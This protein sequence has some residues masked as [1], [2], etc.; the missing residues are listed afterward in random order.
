MSAIKLI[1]YINLTLNEKQANAN[2]LK[3]SER[4]LHIYNTRFGALSVQFALKLVSDNN[5]KGQHIIHYKMSRVEPFKVGAVT[6]QKH[7]TVDT[8]P[9][10][11]YH[12]KIFKL[13]GFWRPESPTYLNRLHI[14]LTHTGFGVG[15]ML[16]LIVTFAYLN[17]LGEKV[18]KFLIFS[19]TL[20]TTVK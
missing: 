14:F 8:R 20:L 9:I 6:E 15:F 3:I 16:T 17:S 13:Y 7:F 10:F 11:D 4:A 19:I 5:R 12:I 2:K 1:G 18:D